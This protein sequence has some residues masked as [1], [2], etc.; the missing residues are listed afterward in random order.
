MSDLTSAEAPASRLAEESV[1]ASVAGTLGVAVIG[2]SFM[3]QAHSNAWR[4]V[5]AVYDGL[6]T[7]RMQTL[8]GR[9]PVKVSG[10][11]ARL[12]W[13]DTAT[14]WRA[15]LERD[16]IDIVDVCTPGHLHAEIAIAALE[17]GKHVLCE[18]PLANDTASAMVLASGFSAM[19]CLPA[20]SAAIATSACRCPGTQTSTMSMSSRSIAARQS[21]PDSAQP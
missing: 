13:S 5:N 2:Y 11:A 20:S 16:D 10:A 9:D 18:K 3:G 15:V 7:V 1:R 6:P 4:N 21:V 14:D 17:A 19:T 12:G 8:V